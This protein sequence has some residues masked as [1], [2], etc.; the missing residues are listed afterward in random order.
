MQVDPEKLITPSEPDCGVL[1]PE[2]TMDCPTCIFANVQ[3]ADVN[4]AAEPTKEKLPSVPFW[5]VVDELRTTFC[6]GLKFV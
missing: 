1:S 4:L 3:E 2:I 6:P 5:F